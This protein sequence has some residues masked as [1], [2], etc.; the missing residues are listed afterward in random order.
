MVGRRLARGVF[1]LAWVCLAG[2]GGTTGDSTSRSPG[3]GGEAAAKTVKFVGFDASEALVRAMKEGKIEGLVVQNPFRMGQ[4]AVRTLVD[5]LEGRKVE[6]QV[7]TGETLATP[8]NMD[9]PEIKALLNPPKE[10]SSGPSTVSA[11]KA[12]KWRI[13]VIP[14]G[15]TH[16]FWQSIHAGA[17]KAAKDLGNVELIW[18]GPQKESERDKQ[19]EL[20]Q[21]AVASRVD[22]VALA[23]L[24]AEALVRPVE[25]VIERGIAVVIFDSALGQTKATAKPIAYVATDNYHGGVLAARRLG[26]VLKG[27][28]KIILLRYAVNSES[29]EKREQGFIDTMAKEFPKITY[30]SQDQYAG[31]TAD[32][33]QKKAESLI[34][35]YRGKVDGIFCCNESSAFGMLRALEAAGM[36]KGRP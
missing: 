7:S 6:P 27:E 9:Q 35:R 23:P 18:Q 8:E 2:C 25:E 13:M 26:E 19:I 17:V 16:E 30:L 3:A 32:T 31:A 28:G 29:T 20:L 33:A 4:L 15:T 11:K 36:V 12:K 34:A 24:D 22:G 21:N 14:K 5:H 1:V 10:A